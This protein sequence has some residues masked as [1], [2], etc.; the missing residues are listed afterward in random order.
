MI[1]TT[2]YLTFCTLLTW[3]FAKS[4]GLELWRADRNKLHRKRGIINHGVNA[5]LWLFMVLTPYLIFW[6][7]VGLSAIVQAGIIALIPRI[8]IYDYVVN[9]YWG[10]P[11]DYIGN[12]AKWDKFLRWQPFPVWSVRLVIALAV[13]VL[14]K[15]TPWIIEEIW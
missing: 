4:D 6:Y 11:L 15:H 8:L 1:E 14:A 5:A 2:L 3:E 9:K 7:Q 12:T 10:K 13:A